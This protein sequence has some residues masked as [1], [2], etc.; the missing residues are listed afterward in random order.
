M[1]TYIAV[2]AAILLLGGCATWDS[3]KKRA[4]EYVCP[5]CKPVIIEKPVPCPE[6]AKI[7]DVVKP[8]PIKP[9]AKAKPKK[10][11]KVQ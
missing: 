6:P 11:D 3:A 9:K 5:E 8:A 10:T 2:I 7:E 1:K 4:Q